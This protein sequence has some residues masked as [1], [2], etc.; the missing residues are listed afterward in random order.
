MVEEYGPFVETEDL[1]STMVT[2]R[3]PMEATVLAGAMDLA[4][5]LDMQD[6]DKKRQ[7]GRMLAEM[8]A[9]KSLLEMM[10]DD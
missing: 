4:N 1:D 8:A 2:A 9:G 6:A 10:P 3:C 7:T 5:G